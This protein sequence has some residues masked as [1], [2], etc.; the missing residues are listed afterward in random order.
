MQSYMHGLHVVPVLFAI[1]VVHLVQAIAVIVM[2][3]D[4][5]VPLCTV[6]VSPADRHPPP[7]YLSMLINGTINASVYNRTLSDP[8]VYNL[9]DPNRTEIQI[10]L[11][12][13][14]QPMTQELFDSA[15]YLCP[16]PPPPWAPPPLPPPSLPPTPSL[17][18]PHNCLPPTS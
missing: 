5:V 18:T 9:T 11:G 10:K 12:V 13:K 7:D 6:L 8:P 15:R 14:L 4:A 2:Y 3:H 17:P 16:S 1:F